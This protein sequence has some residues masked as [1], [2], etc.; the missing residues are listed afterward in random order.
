M[1]RSQRGGI[2]AKLLGVLVVVALL[3]L[4]YLL[5]HPLL[6]AAGEFWVVDEPPQP[7][8]AIILLSDD[9]F[10]ADRAG[11]AAQ[12]YHERW[13]TRI[14]ASGRQLRRY[15]GI[16][17]LMQR[18]LVERGV[19]ADAVIRVPQSADSTRE[20]AQALR[21][22][23]A[24]RGWR[25]ILVVTSNHHTRRARYIYRRVFPAAVELRVVSAR[26]SDYDPDHWWQ[27]R[28]GVKLFFYE[29]LSF[30]VAMWELRE[31]GAPPPGVQM[32]SPA[33]PRPPGLVAN[34]ATWPA[35]HRQFRF[36]CGPWCTILPPSRLLRAAPSSCGSGA[37][38]EE[39][40]PC[41]ASRMRVSHLQL[42]QVL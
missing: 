33:P 18:D 42:R 16:S 7:S 6:R 38:V 40:S 34:T 13:A 21:A 5:R 37:S 23:V 15:A 17:E 41:G 30:C 24:D 35:R 36:T 9:N 2:A 8:D 11:R 29:T 12:L 39:V 27:S 25:R 31:S 10:A 3:G 4:A 26:D 14:V 28:R 20:E 19:P 22:L 1:T 32:L